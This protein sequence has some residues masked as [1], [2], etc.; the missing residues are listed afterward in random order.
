MFNVVLEVSEKEDLKVSLSVDYL[1]LYIKDSIAFTRKLLQLIN[2][3][4]IVAGYKMN[5]KVSSLLRY[6]QQT[7]TER[8][9]GDRIVYNS[10]R[11]KNNHHQQP[12]LP[13][14]KQ[15]WKKKL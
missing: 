8:S 3:F 1:I 5:T 14:T 7:Y 9:Q 10:L 6:K 4:I 2:T 12:P 15:S 11:A 13:P